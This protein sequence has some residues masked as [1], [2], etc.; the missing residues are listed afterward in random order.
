M[1][2]LFSDNKNSTA[3]FL[4]VGTFSI[5]NPCIILELFI[6]NNSSPKLLTGDALVSY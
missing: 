2:S 1:A 6:P 3:H 4:L 5:L